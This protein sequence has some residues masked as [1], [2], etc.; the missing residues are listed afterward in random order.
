[1]TEILFTAVHVFLIHPAFVA[2]I[3]R[4]VTLVSI[5]IYMHAPYEFDLPLDKC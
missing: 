2:K 3:L 1:M 4:Y 5:L